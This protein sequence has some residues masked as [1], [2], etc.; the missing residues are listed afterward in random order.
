MFNA[1]HSVLLLALM[2]TA[3]APSA[4]AV[5]V[6]SIASGLPDCKSFSWNPAP[7][8]EATSMTEQRVRAAVM[9]TLESKGYTQL[10]EN[11]DCRVA[12]HLVAH[13]NPQAKPSVG[14]GMGG[15]SGGTV[16]GIGISLPI[17][18][19]KG[20]TGT[21]TVDVIDSAKN[22]Q[23]WSGAVDAGFASTEITDAEAKSVAEQVLARYPDRK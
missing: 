2:T 11:A 13:Q 5:R 19:K 17:G 3:C 1:K 22:Q 15:G 14:V 4:P 12:Y 23:V 16:G 21:F 18:Q 6:D 20:A 7:G 8:A 10:A 9:Q